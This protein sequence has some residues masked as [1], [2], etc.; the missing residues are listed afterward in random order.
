[1]I[2]KKSSKPNQ[3]KAIWIGSVCAVYREIKN[4]TLTLIFPTC[5]K[6]KYDILFCCLYD[7]ILGKTYIKIGKIKKKHKDETNYWEEKETNSS[8]EMN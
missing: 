6:I 4:I 3:T 8:P 5:Y 1:L 2:F 7:K